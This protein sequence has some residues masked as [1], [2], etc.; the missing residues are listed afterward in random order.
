MAMRYYRRDGT[1]YRDVLEWARDFENLKIKRVAATT[2]LD[3]RLVSTVWLGLNHQVAL[4]GPPLIF[5]TMVF[6]DESRLVEEYCFRYSSES[7]ALEGHHS[8]VQALEEG[9]TPA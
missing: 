9:R 8:V 3:G 2:L 5:E 6:A 4:N 7:A 1:I